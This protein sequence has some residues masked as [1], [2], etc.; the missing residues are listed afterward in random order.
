VCV[1]WGDVKYK[2]LASIKC[3]SVRCK[4]EWRFR[5]PI[6]GDISGC[7]LFSN[8]SHTI[9]YFGKRKT[10]FFLIFI[11]LPL[12]LICYDCNG[13]RFV[14]GG[15]FRILIVHELRDII[16]VGIYAFRRFRKSDKCSPSKY[17]ACK[18]TA[19][20]AE[21]SSLSCVRRFI[22]KWLIVPCNRRS[23]Y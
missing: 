13:F 5:D 8:T 16:F 12:L 21:K 2:R 4:Y 20:E 17:I 9:I 1:W 19:S 22:G 18:T 10:I 3:H 23:Y 14:Y 11:P 15:D 6:I 7:R